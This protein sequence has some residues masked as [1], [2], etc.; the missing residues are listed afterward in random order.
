M[1]LQLGF[2]KNDASTKINQKSIAISVKYFLS[3]HQ[4]N[5][6]LPSSKKDLL[7]K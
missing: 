3:L 1:S 4:R 2:L 7:L 5:S 6:L